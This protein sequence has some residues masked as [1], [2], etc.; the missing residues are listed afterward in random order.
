MT[1]VVETNGNRHC[2]DLRRAYM[3]CKLALILT[4]TSIRT[5]HNYGPKLTTL[6]ANMSFQYARKTY[7]EVEILQTEVLVLRIQAI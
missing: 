2:W 3:F 7:H 4:H 6:Y 5:Q 1:D